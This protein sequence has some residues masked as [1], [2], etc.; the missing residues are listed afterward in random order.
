[1]HDRL[2]DNQASLIYPDLIRYAGELGLDVDRFGED[3]RSR[4]YATRIHRDVDS[5][6]ASGAAGTPTMFVNGRRHEGA[7]DI[8]GL[9]AAIEREL[10]SGL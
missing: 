5:A 6:D 2:M 8:D 10:A 1:M 7:H 3:L 9:A 4:R